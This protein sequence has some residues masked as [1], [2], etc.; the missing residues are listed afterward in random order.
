MLKVLI[1]DKLSPAAIDIFKENGI[2]ADVKTGLDEAALLEIIGDYDGLA[3]RSSTKVT[4][5][6]LAAA[7]KLKIIGRAGIGIDNIDLASSTQNGVIVM[8]AP[9]GNSIT[10]A[11]HAIAM[12]LSLAREIPLADRSTQSGKW[13]KSRFMGMELMG[14]TLG[15]IGCGNVGSLVAERALGLKLKVIAY[16]P[17]LSDERAAQLAI[18]K[19]ELDDLF[20]LSHLITLHTPLTPKTK[21]IINVE[22]LSKMKKG[23]RI[24]NCARG[25]LVDEPALKE[26]LESSQVAGA[27]LDV[28]SQEPAKTNIL[29]GLE[30][31][32]CTPHLGASTTEA[33]EKVAMQI[34]EQISDYLTK[35]VV[36]NAL[37]MPS[38]SAEAAK[39]LEPF[40]ELAEHL[41]AF[42]GQLIKKAID[43]VE[44][45][46][47]GN[48]VQACKDSLTAATLA[49]ALR[50]FLD[51]INMISAPMR[52]KE[53]GIAVSENVK[54]KTGGAYENYIRVLLKDGDEVFSAAGTVFSDGKPRIIQAAGINMEA[55]FTQHM[56]YIEGVDSPGLIGKMGEVLGAANVNVASLALGRADFHGKAAMIVEIDEAASE[57]ALE[58][59]RALEMVKRVE[60]MHFAN[61]I[62]HEENIL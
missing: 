42:T 40:I 33:Q 1:S 25:D 46:Y 43:A 16:D 37:N 62:I 30:N 35:G 27:A 18:E 50:P 32:I 52:A 6:L 45:E 34:A 24:I 58:S 53:A 54:A 10:T 57:Q 23:V 4:P 39:N 21:H 7:K 26:A 61:A 3:V 38:V 5:A 22:N 36:A 19:V 8:N 9:A 2:E 14:K 47:V 17:F 49:G 51:S 44:I 56:L 13:E 15:I 20:A 60:A 28:F 41:G 55:E 59:M 11:E 12:M 48:E 29:F 31:V